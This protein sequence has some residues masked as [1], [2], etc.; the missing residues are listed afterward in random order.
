MR[1]ARQIL[2]IEELRPTS[3]AK[4][5]AE[6]DKALK[7]ESL[8]AFL[9][10]AVLWKHS[11]D[12]WLDRLAHDLTEVCT[13]KQQVDAILKLL[14]ANIEALVQVTA[15]EKLRI[16]ALRPKFIEFFFER[17]IAAAENEEGFD[18]MQKSEFIETC[19]ANA[20]EQLEQEYG[21]DAVDFEV[22]D[23]DLVR[24]AAEVDKLG[25]EWGEERD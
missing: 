23:E 20:A 13:Y 4:F 19:R 15:V 9:E 2:E 18:G 1:F 25:R 24:M 5:L 6:V 12:Y 7:L 22:N 8:D 17:F 16:A 3:H 14:L 21:D 11:N 10:L